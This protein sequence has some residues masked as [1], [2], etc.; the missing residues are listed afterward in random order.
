MQN[1]V[2]K[3]NALINILQTQIHINTTSNWMFFYGGTRSA[4]RDF[5]PY[6]FFLSLSH[7][8]FTIIAANEKQLT[9]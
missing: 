7:R 6:L 9:Q 1:E 8:T 5:A 2:P 3:S 4:C